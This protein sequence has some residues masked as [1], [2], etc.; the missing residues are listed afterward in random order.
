ML[1]YPK[2]F[3]EL[4]QYYLLHVLTLA[5][6]SKTTQNGIDRHNLARQTFDMLEGLTEEAENLPLQSFRERGNSKIIQSL[7]RGHGWR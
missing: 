5:R 1:N 6:A 2:T 7:R 3:E 4:L